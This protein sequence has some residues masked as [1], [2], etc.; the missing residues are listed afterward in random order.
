MQKRPFD[1]VR[2]VSTRLD[3]DDT[4]AHMK[5]IT[6][7]I[8]YSTPRDMIES[9]TTLRGLHEEIAVFGDLSNICR[10]IQN[11]MIRAAN[12]LAIKGAKRRID[13]VV[14][15]WRTPGA[16][17]WD[18]RGRP[19]RRIAE[20]HGL[21]YIA[22]THLLFFNW[23]NRGWRGALQ[24]EFLTFPGVRLLY[25]RIYRTAT[26]ANENLEYFLVVRIF[27]H[28]QQR[29]NYPD[30]SVHPYGVE[31]VRFDA[32]GTWKKLLITESVR[33]TL[34]RRAGGLLRMISKTFLREFHEFPGVVTLI[35]TF[36]RNPWDF[37]ARP[38]AFQAKYTSQ[39]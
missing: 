33:T 13:D 21:K 11:N 32:T 12:K 30:R 24:R 4:V 34:F 23:E 38:Y 27:D 17:L 25:R 18:T 35:N 31:L 28:A 29:Y 39:G 10:G 9:A 22:E 15:H 14:E 26:E 20:L 6:K 19:F 5:E 7:R 3:E 36:C 16:R 8:K 2:D 37:A 1:V